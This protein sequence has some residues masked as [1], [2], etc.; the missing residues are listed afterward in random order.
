MTEMI[1]LLIEPADVWLFRDGRP[2]SPAEGGFAQ[3]RFPPLPATVAGALRT[4]IGYALY[5]GAFARLGD[6]ESSPIR[7]LGPLLIEDKDPLTVYVPTPADLLRASDGAKPPGRLQVRAWPAWVQTAPQ[8]F[9][10]TLFW[11]TDPGHV[12]PAGGWMAVGDFRR[13]QAGQPVSADVIRRASHFY[14]AEARPGIRMDSALNVVH[15][16]GGAF[17]WVNYVRLRPGV[18]LLVGLQ[19]W[20]WPEPD[21][22]RLVE[23]F[24]KVSEA[25]LRLGGERRLAFLRLAPKPIVEE[26]SG[27]GEVSVQLDTFGLRLL[28]PAV[29]EDPNRVPLSTAPGASGPTARVQALVRVPGPS[30]HV[31]WDYLRNAPKSPRRLLPAGSLLVLQTDKPVS[32]NGWMAVGD[33]PTLG[34]GWAV[35]FSIGSPNSVTR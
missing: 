8:P 7:F 29:V 6:A 27:L 19:R 13:W 24:D 10:P 16:E 1:W 4:Y 22:M 31:G 17:Y 21:W 15:P 12:E 3:S 30:V 25:P 5:G 34:Y 20:T 23:H 28:T 2:F 11:S 35:P 14:E 32:G 18:G 26:L 9:S 33:M